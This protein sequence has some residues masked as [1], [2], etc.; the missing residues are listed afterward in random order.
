MQWHFRFGYAVF[1]LLLFRIVWG[2]MGGRWSRFISFIYSPSTVI[3]YFKGRGLPEHSVGHNPMGAGSVFAILGFLLLQVASGLFSD[4]DIAFQGPLAKFVS[5]ARVSTATW[6]HKEVGS[7]VL[8]V[9]IFLHVAAIFYYLHQK[10]E[11]LIHPMLQ[12]DKHLP[13]PMQPSRDDAAS[14]TVAAVVLA[15]CATSV[16]WVVNLGGG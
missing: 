4:D 9:L 5:N 3:A 6:Y 1:T 2:F 7:T 12:G 11:N 8:V 10:K 16:W 14:R 15:L 13:L